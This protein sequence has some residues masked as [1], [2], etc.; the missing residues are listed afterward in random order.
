MNP[1]E[2]KEGIFI[3][4][5]NEDIS[6]FINIYCDKTNLI[7]SGKTSDIPEEIAMECA[8]Y[9]IWDQSIV[10]KNYL[11]DGWFQDWH[12]IEPNFVET[13]AKK[14]LQS[15]VTKPD[16]TIYEYILIWRK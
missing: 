1:I 8:Q 7:Y 3:Q 5:L 15:A 10:F 6:N 12:E 11:N 14:S 2:T 9:E 13:P 16:G 4:G